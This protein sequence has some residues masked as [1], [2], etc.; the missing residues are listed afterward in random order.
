MEMSRLVVVL[1]AVITSQLAWSP[2]FAIDKCNTEYETTCVRK[3][4]CSFHDKIVEERREFRIEYKNPGQKEEV[5]AT[6]E[7]RNGQFS[8]DPAKGYTCDEQPSNN[9]SVLIDTAQKCLTDGEILFDVAHEQI[10][11]CNLSNGVG[12]GN[13]KIESEKRPGSTNKLQSGQEGN[14]VTVGVSS[15]FV[16]VVLLVLVILAAFF[17]RRLHQRRTKQTNNH[18]VEKG[19]PVNE[20]EKC[21]KT[22]DDNEI[23]EE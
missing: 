23:S 17:W 16:I 5:I 2:V 13:P 11:R 15:A 6:C 22:R 3:V 21:L 20:K 9:F 8:C 12:N 1:T 18:D 19:D 10:I 14:G 7:W 4:S